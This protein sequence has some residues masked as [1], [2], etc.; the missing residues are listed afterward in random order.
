[1]V[2]RKT[3]S[4]QKNLSREATP[5]FSSSYG[6]DDCFG[7]IRSPSIDPVPSDSKE[8]PQFYEIESSPELDPQTTCA[9]E[10]FKLPKKK[11]VPE[12][13]IETEPAFQNYDF[14]TLDYLFHKDLDISNQP[15]FYNY[16]ARNHHNSC[17]IDANFELLWNAVL[18]NI[19][20]SKFTI[21]DGNC[22]DRC[23]LQSFRFYHVEDRKSTDN[24]AN[25]ARKFFWNLKDHRGH[26]IFR[27]NMMA[28]CG[29]IMRRLLNN[30]SPNLLSQI[31]GF[32]GAK[33]SRSYICTEAEGDSHNSVEEVD[34]PVFIDLNANLYNI[35][36]NRDQVYINETA[37]K[38]KFEE[39]FKKEHIFQQ[40]LGKCRQE[41]C[42][43][44]MMS[45][46]VIE[47]QLFP[48]FLF[49]LDLCNFVSYGT[50]NVYFP[51]VIQIN[52]N[53]KYTLYGRVYSTMSW[54]CH[55][56]TICYK[57]INGKLCLV[58][59]DNLEQPMVVLTSDLDEAARILKT[60]ENTV[61]T[62]YK[63]F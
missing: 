9:I 34:F 47:D 22:Y 14:L 44:A 30:L 42:S 21:S 13:A 15:K 52:D 11:T 40:K 61:Y 23:L 2:K 62:C 35:L 20:L 39:F 56:Y 5:S 63:K 29:E 48:P 55:F 12:D 4:Q 26:V 10:V 45:R 32:P 46:N 16:I 59:I 8:S 49:I 25:L 27:E 18:P 50:K 37:I 54:G 28:D 43:G 53:V 60:V 19:D 38:T 17:F 36:S 24:A 41:N 31:C 58:K 51:S 1:M 3:A 7:C 33:I 57:L 6:A